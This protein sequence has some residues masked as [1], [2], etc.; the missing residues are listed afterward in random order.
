VTPV[1]G[2][3]ASSQ[4]G[5]EATLQHSDDAREA[6]HAAPIASARALTTPPRTAMLALVPLA[7]IALGFITPPVIP[8]WLWPYHVHF[9][10]PYEDGA[11]WMW[12]IQ[13]VALV[14]AAITLVHG[15]RRSV[16]GLASRIVA[17]LGTLAVLHLPVVMLYMLHGEVWPI[18][19]TSALVIV[20]ALAA[21][22]QAFRARGWRGWLWMLVAY[23][24]A[25]LP[26]ACP[27]W[28]GIFNVFSGGLTFLA[29]DVT[30][31]VLA[32]R[33]LRGLRAQQR[34]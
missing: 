11:S 25:A 8:H 7:V 5:A 30:L 3:D 24:I 10:S 2:D 23:A 18:T 22:V 28:P 34:R 16:P 31:L 21:I 26:Y 14:L 29:G 13:I 17:A 33:E 4:R 32:L 15:R 27:L 9:I 19:V 1:G 6:Q 20:A 12:S